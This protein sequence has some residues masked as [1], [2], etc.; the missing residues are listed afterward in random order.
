[1]SKLAASLAEVRVSKPAP[2]P[3]ASCFPLYGGCDMEDM[4]AVQRLREDQIPWAEVQKIVDDLLEIEENKRIN[5]RRF[6]RHWK[7]ECSCP[8]PTN[9]SKDSS[10]V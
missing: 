6:I 8:K 1:M 4:E 7:S 2:A 9:G 3:R 10:N 5:N